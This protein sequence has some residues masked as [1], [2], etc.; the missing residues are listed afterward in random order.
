MSDNFGP[1]IFGSAGDVQEFTEGY[2]FGGPLGRVKKA[3]AMAGNRATRR[4]VEELQRRAWEADRRIAEQAGYTWNNRD[5]VWTNPNAPAGLQRVAEYQGIESA[6]G[7]Y[8]RRNPG[9]DVQAFLKTPARAAQATA[10]EQPQQPQESPAARASRSAI[11]AQHAGYTYNFDTDEWENP[12]APEGLRVVSVDQDFEQ[13]VRSFKKKGFDPETFL[14]GGTG[15]G[16][17]SRV[18]AAR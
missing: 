9:F 12:S 17:G 6:V 16:A 11:A 14:A 5:R 2:Q 13:V 7:D 15:A 4:E 1:N 3:L 8:A 18:A 10:T